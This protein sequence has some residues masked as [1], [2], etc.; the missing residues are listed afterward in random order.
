[1][2][3]NLYSTNRLK[4]DKFSG[5]GTYL[6]VIQSQ[7]VVS[8]LCRFHVESCVCLR[9]CNR[10]KRVQSQA[11][12]SW[13]VQWEIVGIWVR[14]DYTNT[15]QCVVC[16]E[17]GVEIGLGVLLQGEETIRLSPSHEVCEWSADMH[18]WIFSTP[19]LLM[20]VTRFAYKKNWIVV[21][22]QKLIGNTF[23]PNST[24]NVIKL[25]W[26]FAFHTNRVHLYNTFSS[27]FKKQTRQ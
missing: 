2:V 18:Q 24:Q 4:K 20:C 26:L 17:C 23:Y 1:M 5:R 27:K 7:R 15:I 22:M 12:F 14:Y 19:T 13:K 10:I 9:C 11:M 8:H 21:S 16:V 25:L 3:K 6:A